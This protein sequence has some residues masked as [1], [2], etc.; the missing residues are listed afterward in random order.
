MEKIELGKQIADIFDEGDMYENHFWKDI[1]KHY[2]CI[3]S[4][5]LEWILQIWIY[6]LGKQ[7][8]WMKYRKSFVVEMCFE[9]MDLKVMR[10][11]RGCKALEVMYGYARVVRLE[12]QK[13]TSEIFYT[14][15]KDPLHST[16]I[17]YLMT[18]A[19][20]IGNQQIM[21]YSS[22]SRMVVQQAQNMIVKY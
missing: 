15:S 1:K 11:N 9:L 14:L 19:L 16:D 4:W 5:N 17:F 20:P 21:R 12:I 7:I 2:T 10:D 18:H 6:V 3:E 8:S 13:S 22:W